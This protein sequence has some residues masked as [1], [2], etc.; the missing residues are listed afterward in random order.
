MRYSNLKDGIMYNAFKEKQEKEKI[1][2]QLNKAFLGSI[3]SILT[4][5]MTF[6]VFID[7]ENPQTS[8]RIKIQ[9]NV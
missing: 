4:K 2:K 1:C 8:L 3:S 6:I 7:T 5:T 9:F